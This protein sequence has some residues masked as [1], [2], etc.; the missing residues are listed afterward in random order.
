MK[1]FSSDR[2]LCRLG[3]LL[4]WNGLW[5]LLFFA[6]TGFF[7]IVMPKSVD[8]FWYMYH[9]QPWFEAQGIDL[10][11]NGGNIF[12]SGIPWDAITRTWHERYLTDNVR[13]GNLLVLFFLLLPKWV[14][15]AVMTLLWVY[16]VFAALKLSGI[17]WRK[18]ALVPL[19]LFLWTFGMLWGENYGVM[20]YQFNYLLSLA[21]AMWLLSFLAHRGWGRGASGASACAASLLLGLLLGVTHE[22]VGLPVLSGLVAAMIFHAH[23]R[24]RLVA[25]AAVGVLV[26]TA[27]LMTAPGMLN[28]TQGTVSFSVAGLVTYLT[29]FQT[30]P[31]LLMVAMSFVAVL[32]SGRMRSAM[33]GSLAFILYIVSALASF[34]ILVCTDVGPRGGIW[35]SFISVAALLW[36]LKC[37]SGDIGYFRNSGVLVAATLML[38]AVFA[39]LIVVDKATLEY[40]RS[41]LSMLEWYAPG[42]D[43]SFFGDYRTVA[44]RPLLCGY[45]PDYSIIEYNNTYISQ[46]YRRPSDL[47]DNSPVVIPRELRRADGTVGK[48]LDG[49]MGV[50]LVDGYYYLP[51]DNPVY[52]YNGHHTAYLDADYGSGYSPGVFWIFPFRSETDG[53]IY[54]WLTPW[55]GWYVVHFMDLK[56]IRNAEI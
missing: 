48:P 20:D 56:G 32:T 29:V 35:M 18:S 51:L 36:L 16:T 44:N 37:W 4:C 47:G 49:D 7:F 11:E 34:V 2:L 5:L 14:G 40:R 38:A 25:L 3:P 28:R 42:G 33:I 43:R 24:N 12:S 46:Y 54:L 1:A 55:R 23:G 13:L 26:G 39:R 45:L 21:V 8:D 50:R 17:D 19:A 30:V 27:L 22:G 53:K 41:F 15:S 31:F 52:E 10:P 6:G 9:L